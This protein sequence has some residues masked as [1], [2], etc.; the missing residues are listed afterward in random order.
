MYKGRYIYLLNI[1]LTLT[2]PAPVTT[3][4]F[5]IIEQN[6]L[7]ERGKGKKRASMVKQAA[8]EVVSLG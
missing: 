3:S 6:K 4:Q 2:S 5:K 8:L 1:E 7:E